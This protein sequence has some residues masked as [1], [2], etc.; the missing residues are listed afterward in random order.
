M[1]EQTGEKRASQFNTDLH[2]K[3][4]ISALHGLAYNAAVLGVNIE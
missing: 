1:W 4:P 2:T 3:G